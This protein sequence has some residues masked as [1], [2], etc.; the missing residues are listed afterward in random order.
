MGRRPNLNPK[1]PKKAQEAAA[2]IGAQSPDVQDK[3]DSVTLSI[4]AAVEKRLKKDLTEAMDKESV[5]KIITIFQ[6]TVRAVKRPPTSIQLIK[7]PDT[8]QAD[9]PLKRAERVRDPGLY[10]Q[11]QR[12][13]LRG[14]AQRRLGKE[15]NP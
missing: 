12:E 9:K 3:I 15:T 10:D 13:Y 5:M 7:L 14:S 8:P 4:L 2:S 6:K 11:E 1:P